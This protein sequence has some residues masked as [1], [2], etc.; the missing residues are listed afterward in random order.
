MARRG[1]SRARLQS[2]QMARSDNAHS[3]MY[4]IIIHLG[5]AP[6][7]PISFPDGSHTGTF[8][9]CC[10]VSAIHARAA[11]CLGIANHGGLVQ[12]SYS[13]ARGEPRAKLDAFAIDDAVGES[14]R[15]LRCRLALL[16]P[17]AFEALLDSSIDKGKTLRAWL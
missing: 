5:G 10:P 1:Y 14:A 12:R 16:F 13:G 6:L 9:H 11:T 7:T 3:G 8:R 15:Q 17:L 4:W 2:S